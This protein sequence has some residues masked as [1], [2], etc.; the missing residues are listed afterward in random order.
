M[1]PPRGT[2][3]FGPNEMAQ[4][5]RLEALWRD[6]FRRYNYREIQTPTFEEIELF[7]AKSG[8]GIRD[9]IYDFKDKSGR[10][11]AL[12]PELT[13]PSMRFYFADLKMEP[14]PLRLFYFGPCYR[15]DRPQAGRYREFWQMGCELIG[16]N[17]PEAHAELLFLALRLFEKADLKDVKLRVGH[18][19]FLRGW[20]KRL[21]YATS[22][23]QSPLMRLIDKKE[24]EKL[25]AALEPVARSKPDDVRNFFELFTIESFEQ[26]KLLA[27]DAES[28]GAIAHLVRVRDVLASFGADLSKVRLDPTIARG[29]E[30]YTGLVFELDAPQLGAEKQLLGGGAYDLSAVFGQPPV[31]AVGFAAGFDRTLIALEK[32][33]HPMAGSDALDVIVAPIDP[34]AQVAAVRAASLLRAAGRSVELEPRPV[35]VRKVL[36]RATGLKARVAVFL[37]SK[38]LERGVY[39]VKDLASGAQTEVSEAALADEIRR[40]VGH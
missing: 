38:E 25:K 33:G 5:R 26:I 30:Y 19:G 27:G 21:G 8:P 6:E 37:G 39:A 35:A 9:E 29:L 3:D 24:L 18:L 36:A 34:A 28:Q 16:D 1:Q 10:E 12:R 20:L 14:K 4:R 31:D 32:H 15:Y 40:L 22:A 7:L 23:E 11:L 2:R 17:S 13:A